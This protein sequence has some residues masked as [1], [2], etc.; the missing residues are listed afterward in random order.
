MAVRWYLRFGLSCRDVE[1]LLVERGGEVDHVTLYRWVQRFAPLLAEA[2]RPC[3]RAVGDRWWAD[4]TYVKVAGHWRYVY[5][6]IDKFEQVIDVLV[7]E[8]RDAG[9]ARR[10]FERAIGSTKVTPTEVVTDRARRCTRR[11]STNW[12]RRP[13]TAPSGMP[14]TGWKPTMGS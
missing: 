1:E 11:C 4:E 3:R 2:A 6:A 9:A 7:S 5:R 12:R 10:F 13:G 8:R 14:T